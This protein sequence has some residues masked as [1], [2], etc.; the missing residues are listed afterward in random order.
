MRS[1]TFCSNNRFTGSVNYV[2]ITTAKPSDKYWGI[3]A[4]IVYGDMPL[5]K[6]SAGIVDIRTTLL[7]L[8]SD[9]FN[10]YRRAAGAEEDP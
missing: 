6:L 3:N 1:D 4:D 8:A 9:A 10:D 2:P 7:L 5:L